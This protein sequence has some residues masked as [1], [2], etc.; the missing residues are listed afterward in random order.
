MLCNAHT[1]ITHFLSFNNIY[2]DYL[3]CFASQIGDVNEQDSNDYGKD[4]KRLLAE[5]PAMKKVHGVQD[6]GTHLKGYMVCIHTMC[7]CVN[8]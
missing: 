7:E 3:L 2:K 8:V 4:M 5:V 6:H 1:I